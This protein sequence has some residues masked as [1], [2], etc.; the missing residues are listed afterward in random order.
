M[1]DNTV[2]LHDVHQVGR[3]VIG[4]VYH[5]YD[6]GRESFGF[7]KYMSMFAPHESRTG[8]AYVMSVKYLGEGKFIKT[9][10]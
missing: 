9:D 6:R 8:S 7:T 5:I 2:N 3:L 10:Q 1:E 4:K